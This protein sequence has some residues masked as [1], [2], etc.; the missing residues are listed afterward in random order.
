MSKRAICAEE[1]GGFRTFLI[2]SEKSEG[3]IQKYIRDVRCFQ[4]FL[5]GAE[6][7]KELAVQWKEKLI[8]E[9]YAP[10]TINSMVSSIN[11]FFRFMGWED[12]RVKFLRV[13]RKIFRDSSRVLT[14]TEYER[15]LNVAKIQGR[16][17]LALLMETVC[18]TGIRV[19]EVQY[20]TVEAVQSRVVEISLKGKIRTILLPS[21]LCK[22]LLKYA[23]K[24]KIASGEVFLTRSGTGMSRRQVWAE[25]KSLCAAAKVEP[26]KVFPHN[27]RHLFAR[28]FYKMH[29]DIV[30]LADVLGH[31]SIDTTRIYLI[32]TGREH[33]AYI[34]QLGLV[35]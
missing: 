18:A 1:M 4:V 3:T 14:R 34:E 7:T 33:R 11:C 20:I 26:S 23:K 8:D 6:V 24:Q 19:S 32:S 12:C 2:S 31:S 35:S 28:V 5:A 17:R 22:K 25:M 15:L 30:K 27:L 29:R 10:V 13:Q 16:E 21:R 9:H